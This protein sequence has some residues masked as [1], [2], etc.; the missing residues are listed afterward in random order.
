MSRLGSIY[1]VD[2]K[3]KVPVDSRKLV[4]IKI[5]NKLYPGYLIPDAEGSQPFRTQ[6]DITVDGS[7]YALN[8]GK[9]VGD[10]QFVVME[11]PFLC[12]PGGKIPEL[13]SSKL[14]TSDKLEDRKVEITVNYATT[15]TC[16]RSKFV[17]YVDNL[18]LNI[19]EDK[20]TNSVVYRTIVDARGIW[21]NAK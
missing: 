7:I 5:A 18:S 8:G 6:Y 13:M 19:Q 15:A 1:G 3:P 16:N 20:N 9:G 12:A 2:I 17:G 14:L 10:L 4:T 11:G 21:K